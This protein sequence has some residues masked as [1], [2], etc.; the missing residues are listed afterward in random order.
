MQLINVTG[1]QYSGKGAYLNLL[2]NCKSIGFL[3]KGMEFELFRIND[4]LIDLRK[5][6]VEDWSVQRVDISIHKFLKLCKILSNERASFK[7][8]SLFFKPY[9]HAYSKH[10]PNFEKIT[11][12]FLNQITSHTIKQYW[13]F[14]QFY[15]G[16]LQ[17][18]IKKIISNTVNIKYRNMNNVQYSILDQ[19]K[20]DD[21][22]FDYILS[23]FKSS[24]KK[25]FII[26]NG[27]DSSLV[28]KYSRIYPQIKHIIVD[29]DPRDIYVDFVIKNFNQQ[30]IDHSF[31]KN[32][33]NTYNFIKSKVRKIDSKNVLKVTFEQLYY[34]PHEKAN[35]L[36]NFLNI[37]YKK[38]NFK[39]IFNSF[40]L[41]GST[42]LWKEYPHKSEIKIIEKYLNNQNENHEN[43]FL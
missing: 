21:I 32:F 38:E 6:L 39:K 14:Y 41:N 5:T 33:I 9:G 34:E 30:P 10:F 18:F 40:N 17:S 2:R 1:Y 37:N 22:I 29:R 12:K 3:P 42:E 20:I 31:T 24:K 13:P 15:E 27:F 7:N 8:P 36:M 19:K 28:L 25:Y 43:K 26:D 16:G 35:E 23:I 4:G 11:K